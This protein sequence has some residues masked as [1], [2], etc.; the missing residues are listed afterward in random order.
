[1]PERQAGFI[2]KSRLLSNCIALQINLI[3]SKASPEV[4]TMAA[5]EVKSETMK[6]YGLDAPINNRL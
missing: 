1:L 6:E 3:Y 5:V 4:E 2:M